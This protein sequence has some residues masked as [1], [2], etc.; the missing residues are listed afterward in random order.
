MKRRKSL[1]PY[2]CDDLEVNWGDQTPRVLVPDQL[3]DKGPMCRRIKSKEDRK[4]WCF[5][6]Q[7]PTSLPR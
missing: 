1:R 6:V 5:F 4:S 7:T 3:R 2:G